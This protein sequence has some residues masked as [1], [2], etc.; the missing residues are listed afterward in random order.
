MA[1]DKNLQRFV[2][3]LVKRNQNA[4]EKFR[5]ISSSASGIAFSK[6]VMRG[7]AENDLDL[8]IYTD[9]L[10]SLEIDYKIYY[11]STIFVIESKDCCKNT[12]YIVIDSAS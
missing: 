4:A 2:I 6:A 5:N 7:N 1:R 9:R 3:F 8:F 12:A 11:D 10:L